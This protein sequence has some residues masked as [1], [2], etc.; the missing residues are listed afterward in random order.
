M[1]F[2]GSYIKI[3]AGN[4]AFRHSISTEVAKQ[5]GGIMLDDL[6][7]ALASQRIALSVKEK[8]AVVVYEKAAFAEALARAN[9]LRGDGVCVEMMQ[10]NAGKTREEYRKLAEKRKCLMEYFGAGER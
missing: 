3:G 10:K 1:I 9:E 4:A 7:T 5:G 6:M 2:I 8:H